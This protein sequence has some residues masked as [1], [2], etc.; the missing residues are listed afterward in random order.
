MKNTKL[1]TVDISDNRNVYLLN[2]LQNDGYNA[3]KWN[4]ECIYNIP[5]ILL[6]SPTA[7]V[8]C[9]VPQYSIVFCGKCTD[10]KIAEFAKQNINVHRY[11][12]DPRLITR[13]CQLTAEGALADIINNTPESL[14]WS[15]ILIIGNGNLSFAMA[16]MLKHNTNK[17]DIWAR[18]PKSN[19]QINSYCCNLYSFDDAIQ[20]D[21]YNAIINTVPALVLDCELN[22]I[23]KSCYILD[24]ASKPGGVNFEL[25]K[26][27]GI[28]THH[29]LKV[30][31]IVTP[32]V[33]ATYIKQSVLQVCRREKY[34]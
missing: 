31:S 19:P 7:T 8:D 9:T 22:Q 12:D 28:K 1:I 34:L 16:K 17:P 32:K 2:E 30:P 6:L 27:L 13:N 15:N 23:Q 21:K 29:Y 24:L 18:D 10:T 11:F 3:V 26:S 20:W 5:I 4:D 25:A 33:A 14:L